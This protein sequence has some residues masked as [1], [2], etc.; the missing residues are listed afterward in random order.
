MSYVAIGAGVGGGSATWDITADVTFLGAQS[1]N[2]DMHCLITNGFNFA[3][4]PATNTPVAADQ[5]YMYCTG[6]FARGLANVKIPLRQG[7]RLYL[8]FSAEGAVI[9]HFDDFIS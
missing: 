5:K 7:D 1:M 2:K 4:L 3:G 8:Y 6:S 9:M